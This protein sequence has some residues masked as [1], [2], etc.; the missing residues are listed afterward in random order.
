LPTTPS[1][2]RATICRSNVEEAPMTKRTVLMG[3]LLA[4]VMAAGEAPGQFISRDPGVRGGPAGAGGNIDG[5]TDTQKAVFAAGADD[6]A[7]E[8]TLK[9]GL[10][11]R[12][13]LNSCG[14]CHAFPTVGGTSPR[15][16]PQVEVAT[17]NGAKNIL[18]SFIKENGPVR[19][20]RYRYA[21]DGSRDGGVH[22][23]FVISGRKDEDGTD[24]SGCTIKQDDFEPQFARGNAIFRIP[25]PVF[26]LGLVEAIPDHAI[27]ANQYASL[28]LR[29]ALGILGRPNFTL[30]TPNPN[31]NG[32]DGTVARFGW[33]AQN[34]SLLMFAGEAY[35]VEQGVTNELFPQERD[36]TASCQFAPVPN[37]TTNMDG[38]TAADVL[39]GIQ[40]FAFFMKFLAPPAPVAATAS[41]TRGKQLFASTG[42]ALC[43]TP[44]LKTG[45]SEI[46]GLN[47]Q[48]VN[49]FSDLMLH[50]MGPGLADDILQGGARGEEFRTSPLWG[51]GQRIFFLHDGRTSDL[52][53]AILAHRSPASQRFPASEANQVINRYD[54]L[55]EG[56]KQDL[57]NFLRSL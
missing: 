30:P 50:G 38:A 46:A 34:K 28:A 8:D 13:N 11:P 18:P 49:L 39:G 35:N 33:K 12:F 55:G 51:L 43:H 25:T 54:G 47:K 27:I 52:K 15:V 56:Q 7:E 23:L 31:R 22:A 14:G 9:S 16:N 19:E 21:P 42:C 48:Y 5:L 36:E 17:L 45:P 41:T 44:T 1:F 26:G 53:E 40:K 32:N 57:L 4:L 29:S 2:V 24:A 6:F 37:D 10:G 3:T 20:V